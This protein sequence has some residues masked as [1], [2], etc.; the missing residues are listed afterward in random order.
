MNAFSQAWGWL[1]DGAHWTQPGGI[2][3]R[4]SQHVQLT[5][6]V[7]VIAC[8]IGLPIGLWVGHRRRGEVLA[9][10]AAGIGR[11]LPSFG[12]LALAYPF[13]LRHLPHPFGYWPTLIALIFLAVPPLVTNAYVGVRNADQD[14]V[15]AARGIG[16][17]G[18]QIL[19]NVELPLATPLIL[20]TLRLIAVQVIATATLGA[21][22][23]WGGLGRFVVTGIA[24]GDTGQ[25]L[26]GALLVAALAI[27]V[28][29]AFA[30]AARLATHSGAPARTHL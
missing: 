6:V 24:D 19:F 9:V 26:G 2:L 28:D 30:L 4:L 7:M 10:N 15:D 12:I 8:A 14:T 3:D 27:V 11:A 1:S 21:V 29:L 25:L 5:V 20:S 23:G 17:S 13:T 18:R 16:M 22:V